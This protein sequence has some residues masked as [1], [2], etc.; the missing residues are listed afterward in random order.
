[1]LDSTC[2]IVKIAQVAFMFSLLSLQSAFSIIMILA[3]DV[4]DSDH[5]YRYECIVHFVC[6]VSP[7]GFDRGYR[8]LCHLIL[9][10]GLADCI[11]NAIDAQR[12]IQI[13]LYIHSLLTCWL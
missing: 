8:S 13:V 2:I 5:V 10:Y 1:M 11:I 12:R 4:S 7:R 6:F 9:A 3:G